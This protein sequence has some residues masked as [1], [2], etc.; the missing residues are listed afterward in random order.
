MNT[1][2][3]LNPTSALAIRFLALRRPDVAGELASALASDDPGAA[4]SVASN[5]YAHKRTVP[6]EHIPGLGW[7]VEDFTRFVKNPAPDEKSRMDLLVST[8]DRLCLLPR[9]GNNQE[10]RRSLEEPNGPWRLFDIRDLRLVGMAW[11]QYMA[12]GDTYEVNLGETRVVGY[13]RGTCAV[14]WSDSEWDHKLPDPESAAD[15]RHF[16]I[17]FRA[18]GMGGASAA[19]AEVSRLDSSPGAKLAMSYLDSLWA[20]TGPLVSDPTP[21]SWDGTVPPKP[22]REIPGTLKHAASLI[23]NSEAGSRLREALTGILV[24]S[25]GSNMLRELQALAAAR[26]EQGDEVG[27]NLVHLLCVVCPWPASVLA[28]E[29]IVG[30]M[31]EAG[32][33]P[34]PPPG[35]T[36]L[37]VRQSCGPQVLFE[38]DDPAHLSPTARVAH[39]IEYVPKY[40][41]LNLWDRWTDIRGQHVCGI[42]VKHA[43]VVSDGPQQHEIA[44]A[45]IEV[46]K[47]YHA[48]NLDAAWKLCETQKSGIAGL[49]YAISV[50]ADWVDARGG[51]RESWLQ[52]KLAE[53]D[54]LPC[55]D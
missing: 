23:V 51:V 46:M 14:G 10:W 41:E 26:A 40:G 32:Q 36:W 6:E 8:L 37:R 39:T 45:C 12:L 21:I 18:F 29:A 38:G 13:V 33:M 47:T 19:L 42:A 43:L 35:R 9:R 22:Q 20:H 53:A 27:A 30:I 54:R 3:T 5:K 28:R 1:L 48:W 31:R 15:A 52:E 16:G 34:V 55:N 2:M 11:T 7:L 17:V 49:R 50:E 25:R 24:T 4:L 44:L